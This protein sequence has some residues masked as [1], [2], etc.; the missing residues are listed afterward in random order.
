VP[1]ATYEIWVPAPVDQVW[2]DHAEPGG[3]EKMTPKI[4]RLEMLAPDAGIVQGNL[5]HFR[6]V[7][8]GI[9]M[10]VWKGVYQEVQA[11][12]LF[13]DIALQSPYRAWSHH[14]RFLDKDGGTLIRDEI[15]YEMKFGFLGP[16]ADWL[17]AKRMLNAL[18]R[19]RHK[20]LRTMYP[21]KQQL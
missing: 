2:A 13:H 14:H 19:H 18:F 4:G 16:L 5:V 11:P 17:V 15:E 21:N 20:S 7:L 1:K 8:A 3:L 12:H 9:P 6:L 10:L